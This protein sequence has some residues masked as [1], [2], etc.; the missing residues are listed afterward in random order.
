M[1][2]FSI[3]IYSVHLCVR[4]TRCAHERCYVC[5]DYYEYYIYRERYMGTGTCWTFRVTEMTQ[6]FVF[7]KLTKRVA[8]QSKTI[9]RYVLFFLHPIRS[10]ICIRK[11]STVWFDCSYYLFIIS[12]QSLLHRCIIGVR[13]KVKVIIIND[14]CPLFRT[15]L[16]LTSVIR[17]DFMNQF[18]VLLRFCGNCVSICARRTAKVTQQWILMTIS[19]EENHVHSIVLEWNAEVHWSADA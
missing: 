7:V 8:H 5:A 10:T 15:F 1:T 14:S 2:V 11:R 4:C 16:T 13:H 18:L 12:I 19:F 9:R 3:K 17:D 6:Q